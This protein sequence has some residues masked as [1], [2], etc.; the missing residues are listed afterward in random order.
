[1]A[2]A[3]RV[4]DRTG[5]ILTERWPGRYLDRSK[6]RIMDRVEYTYAAASRICN[7][8]VETIRARA[9]RGKLDK[10]RPTNIGRPTVLMSAEDIAA[11]SAGRPTP[12]HSTPPAAGPDRPGGGPDGGPVQPGGGPDDNGRTI[13][14]LDGIAAQVEMLHATLK[15]EVVAL[16]DALAGERLALASERT[17][18]VRERANADRL[19]S[20]LDVE[21]VRRETIEADLAASRVTLRRIEA[22]RDALRTPPAAPVDTPPVIVTST[23]RRGLLARIFSR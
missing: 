10:G 22:E 18:I 1:M 2:D 20:E 15:G 5:S 14:A 11:I 21:R 3:G 23:P 7:V 16:R 6:G 4:V 17:A 12:D 9:R 19:R 13:K 8:S